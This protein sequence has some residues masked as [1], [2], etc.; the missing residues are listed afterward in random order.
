MKFLSE[1]D[2][3]HFLVFYIP[4]VLVLRVL[5]IWYV[6]R[7]SIQS[8]AGLHVLV[9]PGSTVG[10]EKS[11]LDWLLAQTALHEQANFEFLGD[12]ET[13]VANRQSESQSSAPLA[14]PSDATPITPT[15]LLATSFQRSFSHRETGCTG[16]ILSNQYPAP[17]QFPGFTARMRTLRFVSILS[18]TGIGLDDWS[19]STS[20]ATGNRREIQAGR[21]SRSP[22][23]LGTRLKG[24]PSPAELLRVHLTRREQ[25]AAVAGLEWRALPNL[26][27]LLA[28]QRQDSLRSRAIYSKFTPFSLAV[29]LIQAR[30]SRRNEWM[31]ELEGRV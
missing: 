3:V 26:D 4:V 24:N 25:I 1:I 15:K 2:L 13:R 28:F 21:V 6:N 8:M 22:R 18:C 27:A 14:D 29:K 31:G 7:K 11:D 30:L 9:S 16:L 23:S 5:R 10:L 12:R 19:Y 20:S 17:R